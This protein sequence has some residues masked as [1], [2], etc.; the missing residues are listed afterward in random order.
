M[1]KD[2][3]SHS[4]GLILSKIYTEVY[5]KRICIPVKK[6]IM[7]QTGVKRVAKGGSEWVVKDDNVSV[8]PELLIRLNAAELSIVVQIISELKRYNVF[9]YF[10]YR[11]KGG[12]KERAI[13]SL[14][15][16][17]VLIKTEDIT[18]HIVNPRYIKR[19]GILGVL[20]ASIELVQ[21]KGRINIKFY[22]HLKIPDVFSLGFFG[23][24][25]D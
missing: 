21:Q 12:T 16:K 17:G 4:E 15:K 22:K 1:S 19:G 14:R 3:T 7:R 13:L 24:L 25:I 10:P 6:S 5:D 23:L 2:S 9:W 20:A 18:M 8:D 11:E